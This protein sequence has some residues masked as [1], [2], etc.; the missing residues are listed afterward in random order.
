MGRPFARELDRLDETYSW[1]ANHD[2]VRLVEAVGGVSARPLVAVGS[3]GSYT[4]ADFLAGV[5]QN[6][7]GHVARATTPLEMIATASLKDAAVCLISAGGRNPDIIA[8]L[9]HA[10]ALEPRSLL[11][12]CAAPG[13]RLAELARAY[14]YVDLVDMEPPA[15]KDGF[16]ATNTLLAFLVLTHR[17]YVQA[18]SA[19]APLPRDLSELLHP[20]HTRDEFVREVQGRCSSLWERDTLAVLFGPST[21]AG[22]IDLESKFTE[23][24][25][26]AVQIADYRNFA[27]GRHHW[28]AK[29]GGATAVLALSAQSEQDLANATIALLPPEV[30]VARLE[31]PHSGGAAEISAVVMAMH[32]VAEAGVA[33]RIDPGRPGVPLFGR[34]LYHLKMPAA[35]PRRG[36]P[37][38]A[39]TAAIERKAGEP[40]QT[41]AARG[42]LERWV[43]N[44]DRFLQ[45]LRSTAFGGI[46]FDYDGTLCGRASRWD[47]KLPSAIMA[48]LRRLVECG[49]Y[50]GI[51]T[52]R[53]Q[54]VREPLIDG[55]EPDLR[56]RVWIGYYNGSSIRRLDEDPEP[57][58]NPQPPLDAVYEALQ[59]H[60]IPRATID[61][62][63][64]QLS[65]KFT[66][67]AFEDE[68]SRTVEGIV[69]RCGA[70]GVSVVHSTHSVDVLAPGVS[71]QAL[72]ER[73]RQELRSSDRRT[74]ILCIGDR[75][76][77]PGNDHALLTEPSSL[78]VDEVSPDPLT[79]W[80]LA[81]LGYRGVQ[82]TAEYLAALHIE[83]AAARF[84][85][86]QLIRERR[87]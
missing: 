35:C 82:A 2:I 62:R 66:A 32:V 33:R 29:R 4:A 53:G 3:G 23:A 21:R 77:W 80:N 15:G 9:E 11:V 37:T 84:R 19:V 48:A 50:V 36:D 51:A 68:V 45:N 87:P 10:I 38:A 46:V 1:A 74:A 12:M 60:K 49:V 57:R 28:L 47:K 8:A 65:V 43:E 6:L 72:V 41:L 59:S 85:P 30:A 58:A 81:P 40:C 67:M 25:L 69:V 42:E 79:C 31:I 63:R 70:T 16:L 17:A 39:R 27:H 54:S 61:A 13:S 18:L 52:G 44:Y 75:G 64:T 24:A 71:K 26:G 5:H 76:R 20:G 56:T 7:S 86:E 14:E 34:K 78:S 55:L 22:A 83:E 73:L